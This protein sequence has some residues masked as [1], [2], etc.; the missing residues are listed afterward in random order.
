[1][2]C[3]RCKEKISVKPN[4][5]TTG[6]ATDDKENKICYDCCGKIDAD[7][8]IQ[9]VR[10]TYYLTETCDGY[11]VINWP[12]TMRIPVRSHK[13]GR[14]NFARTRTDVWFQFRDRYF[15]GVQYGDNSQ[16]LHI[17]RL[18]D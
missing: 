8:L 3:S 6:Y 14:H 2:K 16:L 7:W 15:H 4:S 9:H 5:I 17:R 13:S 10:S 11:E 12:G 18:K 1:M